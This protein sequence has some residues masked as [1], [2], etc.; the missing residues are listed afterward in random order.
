MLPILRGR[1]CL[2]LANNMVALRGLGSCSTS[3]GPLPISLPDLSPHEEKFILGQLKAIRHLS[4]QDTAKLTW[5]QC[6]ALMRMEFRNYHL[7]DGE[8]LTKRD[9]GVYK[10]VESRTLALRM[11]AALRDLGVDEQEVNKYQGIFAFRP[12]ELPRLVHAANLLDVPLV[13]VTKK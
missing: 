12:R 11:C 13:E 9:K 3:K 6:L 5:P 7:K 4:L 8:R 2:R 1:S 10:R